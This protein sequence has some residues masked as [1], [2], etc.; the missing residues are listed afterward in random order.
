MKHIF[1][2][3]G[4]H[5]G[6]LVKRLDTLTT[7][8]KLYGDNIT[9]DEIHLFEPQPEHELSLTK[10]S[11]SDERVQYHK[12]AV[13]IYDGTATFYVK[14][15]IGYCSSTLDQTKTTGRLHN[16]ITVN[17]VDVV[18][19][20]EENTSDADFV[21]IDMDIECE[22]Y[23][24]LPKLL[25]SEVL[26]RIK[27]VSV[28]FHRSKSAHWAKNSMDLQIEQEVKQTL[29]NKFLDHDKYYA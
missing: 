23:N 16:T 13:S 29:Q 6:S 3:F 24:L 17:V 5:N 11:E 28:E 25:K 27:F 9:W 22:E 19:W 20:I 8:D 26:N 21:A 10:L 1:L 15:D 12:K 18:K 4:A 7:N 14:G 2:F